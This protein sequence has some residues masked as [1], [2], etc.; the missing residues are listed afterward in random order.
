MS[1]LG[2]SR[3]RV[4]DDSTCAKCT[5]RLRDKI[6]DKGKEKRITSRTEAAN[7]T[8]DYG[9][10]VQDGDIICGN[11][12]SALRG[13]KYKKEMLE[14][15]QNSNM[16]PDFLFIERRDL[17]LT[18]NMSNISE[19]QRSESQ[20]S[21]QSLQSYNDSQPLTQSETQSSNLTPSNN[22]NQETEGQSQS[23]T[24][25]SE[26]QTS[27][28]A[29][30]YVEPPVKDPSE[31]VKMPFNR[32]VASKKRCFI[33][34]SVQNLRDVP[35][36][37]RIQ[38]FMKNRIFIPKRNRCC[39][40]HLLGKRFYDN[41]LSEMTIFSNESEIEV[42]EVQNFMEKLS[43]NAVARVIDKIGNLDMSDERVKSL[44]GFTWS[45]VLNLRKLL[46]TMRDSDNRNVLQALVIFLFKLRSGNSNPI[47]AAVMQLEERIVS[48]S[49]HAVLNC[50]EKEVLPKYFGVHCK[51]REFFISQTAPIAHLLH[52]ITNK[53]VVICDGTYLRHEKSSNNIYQRKSYSGQKKTPLCKPF[54][55]CTS[56]GYVIDVPGPFNGNQNDAQ[57]LKHVLAD[58]NGISTILKPG[59]V[60]ILDRGFRDVVEFLETEGYV[61][62]MPSLKGKKNQLTTEESNY[63]RYVTKL[64]WVV[65]SIHGILGQK[66]RL[67]HNQFRNTML[68]SA[69]TF[70][71]IANLLQNLF[72][73]RLNILDDKTKI[74]VERM[75]STNLNANP[76]A[77]RIEKYNLN[78]KV[79]PFETTTTEEILDF[80]ELTLED[81]EVLFTGSYQLAQAI[82]YLGEM[83]EE[84]GTLSLKFLKEEP[85]IIRFEVR[86]RHINAKTYKCYV[87]Y[88]KDEVGIDAITGYCCTCANGLRTVGCCSHVASLIYHLSYGRY[89]SRIIRPSEVLTNIFDMDNICP[90]IDEDSD[91]D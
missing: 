88:D 54:T 36:D 66:Y 83:L 30:V 85:G 53:L 31:T 50:F 7:F 4:R 55:I 80:P 62:L 63:S 28:E 19:Q 44:T 2:E 49:I 12:Y 22:D 26:S 15:A 61:V 91:E 78:R 86:S 27:S 73:K 8:S 20:N 72:G 52:D 47:I 89:L 87:Q 81:L 35:F 57:I 25:K 10:H 59:D 1:N 3:K 38:V 21:N 90:V 76:L 42:E 13:K 46:T 45:D 34:N 70:C 69:G 17:Q 41:E 40:N 56:N 68:P 11:C 37:A 33:C 48:E 24:T 84:D 14:A 18:D 82:S 51:D 77:E 32:V 71:K 67:L 43:K 39:K 74:I 58:S 65:E 9:L 6:R 60:F 16:D 64:R 23:T 5:R 79:V 29:S 75:K